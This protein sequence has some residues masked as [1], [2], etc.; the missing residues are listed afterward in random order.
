MNEISTHFLCTSNYNK[1]SR[2]GRTLGPLKFSRFID[3]DFID[4]AN[5]KKVAD[6]VILCYLVPGDSLLHL[7]ASTGGEQAGL[8]LTSH[9]AEPNHV[10][11]HGLTPLHVSAQAG[12]AKLVSELL[13]RFAGIPRSLQNCFYSKLT[14]LF[15]IVLLIMLLS[16]LVRF[17]FFQVLIG[18]VAARRFRLVL[19]WFSFVFLYSRFFQRSER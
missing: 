3:F 4:S 14:L 19:F 6:C 11:K 9:G 16:L 15:I 2:M 13:N 12:L 18:S 1:R 7:A 10:N 8:F 17:F 5:N